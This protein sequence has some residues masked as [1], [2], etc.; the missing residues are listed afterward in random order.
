M[1]EQRN[2]LWVDI[3][4]EP[5]PFQDQSRVTKQ[6]IFDLVT[7]AL[8]F[9]ASPLETQEDYDEH[10]RRVLELISRIPV[11]SEG[12]KALAFLLVRIASTHTG[13][14]LEDI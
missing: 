4:G 12:V 14:D 10:I 9:E 8:R 7:E 6:A 11:T 13:E 2:N 3:E 5:P 1:T